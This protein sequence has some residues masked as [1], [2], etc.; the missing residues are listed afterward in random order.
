MNPK[1]EGAVIGANSEDVVGGMIGKKAGSTV[2]G[3]ILGAT[4]GR[5]G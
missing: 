3:P 1:Q 5:L 2:V 4:V